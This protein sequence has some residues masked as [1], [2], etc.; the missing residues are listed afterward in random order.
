MSKLEFWKVLIKFAQ[1]WCN[2][3]FQAIKS[4]TSSFENLMTKKRD[5][6]PQ[7][8]NFFFSSSQETFC[9]F[10]IQFMTTWERSYALCSESW[11]RLIKIILFARGEQFSWFFSIKS[12]KELASSRSECNWKK[13]WAEVSVKI[14]SSKRKTCRRCTFPENLLFFS[15]ISQTVYVVIVM[16][17]KV[18]VMF[19]LCWTSEIMR[20]GMDTFAVFF[21][22]LISQFSVTSRRQFRISLNCCWNLWHEHLCWVFC[23]AN[24]Y[25]ICFVQFQLYNSSMRIGKYALTNVK[26]R[27]ASI[28]MRA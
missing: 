1:Q 17:E 10:S 11:F 13:F 24:N 23:S 28:Y 5:A 18:C 9:V 21:L 12:H 6:K 20:L 15:F 2:S 25:I 16:H 26:C 27:C 8:F 4:A 22:S 19:M 14:P 7:K 3:K